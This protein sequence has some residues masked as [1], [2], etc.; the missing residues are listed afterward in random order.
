MQRMLKIP[1]ASATAIRRDEFRKLLEAVMKKVPVSSG[2]D[3][4]LYAS[5]Y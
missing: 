4:P 2:N 3:I 5:G 1:S